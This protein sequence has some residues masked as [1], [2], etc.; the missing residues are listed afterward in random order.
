[1][2]SPT[3]PIPLNERLTLEPKEVA[4]LLGCCTRT[5]YRMIHKE[6]LPTFQLWRG[7]NF[8]IRRVDL[9]KWLEVRADIE[10]A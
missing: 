4:M 9:D 6:G 2:D 10:A 5:V 3:T 8:L 7:A 1:M